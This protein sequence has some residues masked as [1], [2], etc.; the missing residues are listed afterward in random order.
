MPEPQPNYRIASVAPNQIEIE[1]LDPIEFKGSSDVPLT[2]G[3]Y[4][5]IA[6]DDGLAIIAVVK[7]FRLQSRALESPD[8]GTQQTS[9]MLQ[10]Q[11]VGFLD[12]D[13]KFKRGGQQIA[14]PPT[15][16]EVANR[17][18]LRTI[19]QPDDPLRAY[20][21]GFLAQ[22]PT[23]PVMINGDRFFGKHIAIV[24]ATGS[25]KSCTVAK[26]LQE[27]M[28]QSADQTGRSVLN[29]S[30]VV[31]FDI[32]GEYASAFPEAN[33]ISI[34][35]LILPYWLMNSEEL[36]EMFIEGRE[37]NSHNQVSQ[38]KRAVTM[39]KQKYNT[40]C[41]QITYDSPV[42]F[43]IN[44][45]HRYIQN[46]NN[47]TKNAD[48]HELAIKNSDVLDGI[49]E[50][51]WLFEDLEFEEKVRSKINDG[52]YAGEFHSFVSRLETKLNDERLSFLLHPTNELGVE[53]QTQDLELI[54]RQ[55]LGYK[56]LSEANIT[57]VDLSGIPFEV[58]SVV[59]ALATR[60]IFD[61]KL[62]FKKT[63]NLGEELP[64]HLVYEEAHRYV[65]NSTASQFSSVRRSIERVAKEGR[66]YGLSLMIVS[67]RPSEISETI[68]S[69]CSNFI[70]MR[71][72]NPADQTYVRR[73]LPDELG[74]LQ[75]L[76][77]R[78]NKESVSCLGTLSRSRL[79]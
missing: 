69:Q 65:P 42:F 1:I 49:D 39:N 55:F 76:F 30:H 38:F 58:L 46:L 22:D 70:A 63:R 29:N 8:G 54:L 35:N 44:E 7:S 3:S 36:E 37:M 51:L 23:I 24:G 48:S 78:L 75:M 52:A 18:V 71:L 47:A 59:V 11:P 53:L 20:T 32:H 17:S 12:E 26:V 67:Q 61:F 19:Y 21:F 41:G 66:K 31:L 68:F 34:E 60:L 45:V 73:L 74:V 16:V 43:S 28:K 13:G 79:S 56:P 2:I 15:H 62:H 10:A 72:T 77:P 50:K 6:D 27:G 64:L 14:I 33:L 9:F 57:I 5:K 4:L 40:N 25:G